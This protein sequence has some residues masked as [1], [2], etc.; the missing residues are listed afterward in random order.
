MLTLNT[1]VLISLCRVH[2]L[3]Y[4]HNNYREVIIFLSLSYIMAHSDIA[5]HSLPAFDPY[6]LKHHLDSCFTRISGM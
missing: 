4:T 3:Q 1:F 5:A 2:F 6:T